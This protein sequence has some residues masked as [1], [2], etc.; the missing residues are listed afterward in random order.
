M[1]ETAQQHD[2]VGYFIDGFKHFVWV[3][4]SQ[5]RELLNARPIL[6]NPVH[7]R[8]IDGNKIAMD[9]GVN[10]YMTDKALCVLRDLT[11]Y[12]VLFEK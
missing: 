4:A 1:V 8:Y 10:W 9:N 7:I 11:S 2:V 5:N 12:D 6:I 3:T